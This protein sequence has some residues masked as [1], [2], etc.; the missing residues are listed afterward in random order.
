M[1]NLIADLKELVIQEQTKSKISQWKTI[2][3]ITVEVN[4]KLFSF[5]R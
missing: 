4:K 2:T 5:E 1:N 3:N